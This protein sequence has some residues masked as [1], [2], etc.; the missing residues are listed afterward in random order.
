MSEQLKDV[1]YVDSGD[2]KEFQ[3]FAKAHPDQNCIYI[4]DETFLRGKTPGLI[5]RI[6]N[7]E[8]R[9]N[10]HPITEMIER[11]YVDWKDFFEEKELD[12]EL[13][14]TGLTDEDLQY[15]IE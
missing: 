4:A 9:W 5:K 12:I 13:K 8:R 10:Y 6:G 11:C 15:G 1:I 14:K 3:D 7:F 2:W